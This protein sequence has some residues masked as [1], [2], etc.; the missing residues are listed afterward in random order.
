MSTKKEIIQIVDYEF[1]YN[2]S[3]GGSKS[4]VSAPTFSQAFRWFDKFNSKFIGVVN[5]RH[6]HGFIYTIY[7]SGDEKYGGGPYLDRLEAEQF[8][9]DKLINIANTQ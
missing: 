1:F 6:G 3:K 4:L 8:C 7:D 9:L 2:L 5:F